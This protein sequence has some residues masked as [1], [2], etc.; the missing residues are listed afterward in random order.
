MVEL[1]TVT[2]FAAV[3]SALYDD[4]HFVIRLS[5]YKGEHCILINIKAATEE[6]IHTGWPVVHSIHA[7]VGRLW[8]EGLGTF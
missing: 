6:S 4:I 8:N 5:S 3:V 7:L 1:D 2:V